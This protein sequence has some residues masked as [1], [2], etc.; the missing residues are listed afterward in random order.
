MQ[1]GQNIQT[2]RGHADIVG[3]V[4]YSPDGRRLVSVGYEGDLKVWD[5][6]PQNDIR[7]R[8]LGPF[9]GW[10]TGVA[11][12]PDGQRLVFSSDK[13]TV[14]IWD[15]TV[16]QEHELRTLQGEGGRAWSVAFSPDGGQIAAGF[17]DWREEKTPSLVRVWDGET[18]REVHSFKGPTGVA[19]DVAFSL[20][21]RLIACGGGAYHR[22]SEVKVWE[23]ET[24]R[25]RP[26]LTGHQHGVTRV[27]FAPGGARLVSSGPGAVKFW[28]ISS[29]RLI[30]DGLVPSHNDAS[31]LSLALSLDGRRVAS[32]SDGKTVK[33]WDPKTLEVYFTLR[34]HTG[35]IQWIAFSPDGK[36]IA[37]A[38]MDRTVKVWDT[39]T[40]QEALTLRGHLDGV[41]C[42]AFSPDGQRIASAGDRSVRIWDATSRTE[43]AIQGAHALR[44]K[45]SE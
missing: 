32:T 43:Q 38:S 9:D 27:V 20:D 6:S 4:A 3:D 35:V 44:T 22:P 26:A 21:G 12:S 33:I 19:R 10:P 45:S 15:V 42:L 23:L 16:G 40:G 1:T 39:E 14:N 41:Y 29:G 31:A 11:F 30:H 24:G 5:A 17:G 2:Y 8:T 13:G 34:G 28:D 18:G 25:E 7:A 36:R 37:S